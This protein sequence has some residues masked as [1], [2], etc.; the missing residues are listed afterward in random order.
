MLKTIATIFA[1]ALSFNASAQDY[2]NKPI[3]LVVPF[4]PGGT[5]DLMGRIIAERLSAHLGQPVIVNNRAG[6][7]GII[8]TGYVAKAP[9]DGYTLL[10]GTQGQVLQPLLYKNLDFDSNKDFLTV[11]TFASVPNVL[12][13]SL[14][15]PANT[16]SEFVEHAKSNP[17]S[18]NM[19]SA[20]VGSINHLVGE[21]FQDRAK[22]KLTHIPYKGAAPAT[23]DLLSGE[24]NAL[25]VNLPNVMS[26][27]S[28]G[29]IRLLGVASEQRAPSIPD[30]PTF[31]EGGVKNAVLDS[32][33]G[34]MVSAKTPEPVV[35]KIQD[36]VLAM[37]QEPDFTA[38]LVEQGASPFANDTAASAKIMEDELKLW[39]PIVKKLNI[40]MD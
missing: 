8:G 11:A 40:Q 29:K 12:A 23:A 13:V 28:A 31:A 22:V 37:T 7:G 25:F 5:V 6:A 34:V 14:N 19:G 17:G 33:Y 26:Y 30:V 39:A 21:V 4:A 20:G 2:P 15:T 9:A 10:V 18:I 32:W 24:V 3:T 1:L 16:M 38:K 35:K 27:V 36:A